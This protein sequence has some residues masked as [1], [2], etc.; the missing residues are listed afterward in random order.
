MDGCSG[1]AV[2]NIG[3]GNEEVADFG[4]E[5]IRRIAFT[6]LSRWTVSAIGSSQVSMLAMAIV[7]CGHARTGIEDVLE[8]EKGVPATNKM[9]VERV[10]R[11]AKELGR[12]IA[13]TNE[14]RE[15]L[16]IKKTS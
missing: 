13:T 5:H 2:A 1:S 8:Y 10:V 7:L 11:L 14:A 4:R 9:L 12:D 15:I 6:H 16:N 3:H